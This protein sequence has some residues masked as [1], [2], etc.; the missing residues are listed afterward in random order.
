MG[1][2]GGVDEAAN[3][4]TNPGIGPHA[5]THVHLET[6]CDIA[7]YIAFQNN[8]V[9]RI[10]LVW[11]YRKCRRFSDSA[12]IYERHDTEGSLG[13]SCNLATLPNSQ[14]PN[15]C[16]VALLYSVLAT[17]TLSLL[18]GT[19]A[20]ASGNPAPLM[21]QLNCFVPILAGSVPESIIAFPAGRNMCCLTRNSGR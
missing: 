3:P 13:E 2:V 1:G 5:D 17:G 4:R 10:E 16:I 12:Q 11:S 15:L 20:H 21:L 19:D 9:L 14:I 6:G 18:S 7:T 8:N